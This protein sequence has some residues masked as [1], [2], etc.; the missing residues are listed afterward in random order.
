MY[1]SLI[2]WLDIPCI[3]KPFVSRDSAND[4]TYGTDI[5]TTCYL[6]GKVR[7]VENRDGNQ[8]ISNT[9]VYLRGTEVIGYDD[10]ITLHGK[11]FHIK[12]MSEFYANGS[13]SIWVVYI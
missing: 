4:K 7:V 6:E 2:E 5:N 11:S 12:A 1:E 13:R 9:A 8:V 10:I 3:I